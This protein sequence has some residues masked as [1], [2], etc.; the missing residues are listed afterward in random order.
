MF[1]RNSKSPKVTGITARRSHRNS[2]SASRRI[3]R[4]TSYRRPRQPLSVRNATNAARR[5]PAAVRLPRTLARPQ[6]GEVDR[7]PIESAHPE[8][9][10]IPT[11]YIRKG[12]TVT[13]NEYVLIPS[14]LAACLFIIH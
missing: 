10:H 1:V 7:K 11:E 14:V 2:L 4:K 5:E 9:A 13:G 12:L 8:L 3:L 6:V